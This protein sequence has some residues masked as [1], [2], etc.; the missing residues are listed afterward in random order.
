MN[1]PIV[2]IV[3]IY[4]SNIMSLMLLLCVFVWSI[5]CVVRTVVLCMYGFVF[6]CPS[7]SISM[8]PLI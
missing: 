5:K 1:N 3:V 4:L 6:V 8:K 7:S 2:L